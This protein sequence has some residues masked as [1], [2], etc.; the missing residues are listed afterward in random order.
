MRRL[1]IIGGGF[2]GVYAALS[3]A[4]QTAGHRSVAIELVTRDR[5]LT[6]RPRLYEEDIDT[7]RVP[8]DGVLTPVGVRLVVGTVTDLDT[9]QRTLRLIVDGDQRVMRY[10]AAVL[11]PGSSAIEPP[12]DTRPFG[13]DSFDEA[14]RLRRH[15]DTLTAEGE[16]KGPGQWTA[17]VVGG[18]FT[19]L[20]VATELAARLR[21]RRR[22]VGWA[23]D[24]R[25]VLVEREST[26]APG[27]GP[28]ARAAIAD[29]LRCD[30][31]E[32]RP[33][34]SVSR[35][36][37]HLATLSD[38]STVAAQTVVWAGGQRA[39]ALTHQVGDEVGIQP[40]AHGRLPVDECL[41]VAGVEQLFAAGDVAAAATSPGRAAVMSCQHAIPQG[42]IAGHNAAAL[43]CG[44]QP[45]PYRQPGYITC[46]DL[47]EWGAL[48]T[49]GWDRN[50]IIAAGADGKRVKR[51]I[52]RHFI[53]PNTTSAATLLA[54]GRPE[55][56]DAFTAWLQGIVLGTRPLRGWLVARADDRPD[57]VE[58]GRSRMVAS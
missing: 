1:V 31:V 11:A 23:D 55:R 19:G 18:G 34:T 37:R 13:V 32:A 17:V 22:T 50:H 26:V 7:A 42:K 53:Y 14:A 57:R 8:L 38:G 20:E 49:R 6:V 51:W 41:S 52:N 58:R 46:L 28:R 16:G 54:D 12:W 35:V 3:A 24:V 27:F 33:G 29:A 39:S 4:R 10:D 30:G 9:A 56:S 15:L 36:D 25:V 2:A 43:L 48:V 5:H 44:Q 21:A 45:R 40:D 47:G